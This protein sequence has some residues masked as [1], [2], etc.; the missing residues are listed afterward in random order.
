MRALLIV[1]L[2]AGLTAPAAAHQSS[3]TYADAH[4]DG[5]A[6]DYRIRIE[7][8]D[9]AEPIG[10]AAAA[11]VGL[12]SITPAEWRHLA[13]YVTARVDVADGALACAVSEASAGADGDQA[14]VQW[15][16]LCPAPIT[17]LVITYRLFFDLDPSHNGALRV[18]AA[19]GATADTIFVGDARR[20]AWVLGAA[21]PSGALAFIRAGGH[22]VATGLDHVAFVLALLIALVVVGSPDGWRRRPI[23]PALRA[24]AGVVSAFTI[25]HSLTL[26]AA[27]LG[28]VS[29]PIRVVESLIAVSIV[30]TAVT[31]V[32]R[33]D[34]GWRFAVTFGFGLMHGLGFARM[35]TPL[36]PPGDV[37]VP[38]LCF[39]VGVELAQLAI[40]AVAL[41]AAWLLV[42]A[43]GPRRYRELALPILAGGLALVGTIW[44]VE[45]AAGIVL[46]GL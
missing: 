24:T 7:P 46:L 29:L 15:R 17:R 20:F 12:A 35:L 13:T 14:I 41:P 37:V 2:L 32:V 5:N 42:T 22:H 25:A 26:I 23:G 18:T 4:V 6:V 34:L 44:L 45:R 38:L 10:R 16:A 33:P 36:L 1:A 9:L 40:V 21:P 3:I 30:W 8:G 31:A 43:I 11:S 27:A 39:N 19:T 28:W